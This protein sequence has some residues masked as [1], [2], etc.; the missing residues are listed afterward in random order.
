MHFKYVGL[1]LTDDYV[2]TCLG[3]SGT[4]H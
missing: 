3:Q 2:T 4:F 1:K